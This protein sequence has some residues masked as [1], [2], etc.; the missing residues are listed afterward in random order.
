MVQVAVEEDE[1]VVM[2]VVEENE[3]WRMVHWCW[4][5]WRRRRWR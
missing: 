2:V 1:E 5:L 4:W 3:V